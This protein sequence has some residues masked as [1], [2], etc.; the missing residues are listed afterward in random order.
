[1]TATYRTNEYNRA[2]LARL[3]EQQIT[4]VTVEEPSL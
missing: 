1:V 4:A 3:L 2:E